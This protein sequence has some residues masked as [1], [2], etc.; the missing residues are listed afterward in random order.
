MLLINPDCVVSWR[1]VL[2]YVSS[3]GRVRNRQPVVGSTPSTKAKAQK[4]ELLLMKGQMTPR[5]FEYTAPER[6]QKPPRT[7]KSLVIGLIGRIRLPPPEVRILLKSAT[8]SF[9][10]HLNCRHRA[11]D[12]LARLY[13]GARLGGLVRLG[14][15]DS[16]RT[17]WENLR[18]AA[19]RVF[20][21]PHR[22]RTQVRRG[23]SQ[24]GS[25]HP[26]A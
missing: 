19:P 14:S 7:P 17:S 26:L 24:R 11:Q 1:T 22:V 18:D 5:T 13:C 10:H 23:N 3:T 12:L 4:G 8:L 21:A 25:I 15:A 6:V 2:E 16:G 20:H 9:H